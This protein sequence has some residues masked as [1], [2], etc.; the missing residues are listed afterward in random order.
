M[1][2]RGVFWIIA[3]ALGDRA[4]WRC[5][6]NG[7]AEDPR[8]VWQRMNRLDLA[9]LRCQSER[10]WGN[11]Q[12]SRGVAEVQ[13]RLDS[14]IGRLVDGDAVM[15]TQ[16]RDPLTGP[17][18]AIARDQS[19]PVQDAGDEIIIG[20]QHQLPH[21]GNHIICRAV[22]LP[23]PSLWQAYLA[24]N[25][26]DPMDEQNDLGRLQIDVGDYFMDDGA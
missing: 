20:D 21:S 16:R 25:A 9:S 19:V 13:P 17:A 2:S 18:I 7:A 3:C 12:K 11:M 6:E 8:T 23:A 4:C 5:G 10:S 24:M 14:I 26:P 1:R 15:R 22:A